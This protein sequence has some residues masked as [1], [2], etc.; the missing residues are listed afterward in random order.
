MKNT[1]HLVTPYITFK[2]LT[3]DFELDVKPRKKYVFSLDMKYQNKAEIV[4]VIII[5]LYFAIEDY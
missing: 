4:Q 1:M 2:T 5:L 3:S